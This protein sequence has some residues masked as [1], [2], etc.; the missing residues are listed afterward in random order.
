M[1]DIP[2]IINPNKTAN[3]DERVITDERGEFQV[4]LTEP[5]PQ[6]SGFPSV[7]V[8]LSWDNGVE[9]ERILHDKVGMMAQKIATSPGVERIVW[10]NR[11]RSSCGFLLRRGTYKL[12]G[13]VNGNLV[14]TR[15]VISQTDP[16]RADWEDFKHE[17]GIY[18]TDAFQD[19]CVE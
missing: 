18:V 11:A 5:L 1:F 6:T 19:L 8:I 9:V 16:A 13:F 12:Q 14:T 2:G 17:H 7:E 15:Q 10:G 3:A 4:F